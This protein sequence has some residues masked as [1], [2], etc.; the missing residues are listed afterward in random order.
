MLFKAIFFFP[1]ITYVFKR[2]NMA[3]VLQKPPLL[4]PAPTLC[5]SHPN[6]HRPHANEKCFQENILQV[7]TKY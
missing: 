2:L 5:W 7:T 6:Q 1:S 3:Y 4:L